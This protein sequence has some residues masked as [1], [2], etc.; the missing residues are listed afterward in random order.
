VKKKDVKY[1]VFIGLILSVIVVYEIMKPK[2]IDWS[3]TLEKDDKIPYGT[4]V[5]YNT[6]VD[7]FP[8]QDIID[9][10]HTVFETYDYEDNELKN[11]L[12]IS[13]DFEPD[14]YDTESILNLAEKGN[15]IFISAHYFGGLFSDTLNLKTE[16]SSFFDT[17]SVL[18]FY[19]Y[20]IKQEIPYKYGKSASNYYFSSID[21]SNTEILAYSENGKPVY[22]RHKHGLGR[23][24]INSVPEAFTNYAMVTEE[25]YEF[26]YSALSYL[27][28]R[29]IVWDSYYKTYRKAEKSPMSFIFDNVSFKYAYYLLLLTALLFVLFTA[30]RRQRIIPVMKPFKNTSLDFIKTIGRLYY[31][32][33]NHKDIA[34]KKFNY[35]QHYVQS[36]YYIN[37]ADAEN[38]Y[39]RLAEKTG[40][41]IDTIKKVML[42][43]KNISSLDQISNQ[44]LILFNNYIEDFYENCK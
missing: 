24:Y 25:N 44:Q 23:F 27:P 1:Y 33:K 18:N 8:F 41:D 15:D 12:F 13:K 30:K 28:V 38:T 5:L 2:P 10:E 43:Y 32:S 11:Y 22:I 6:L 34:L 31:H 36:K 42:L 7:I 20:K 29:D 35:L 21:T 40:S 16:L 17:S 4:F 39:E 37:I 19:N 26:A 9:S 14:K 3:F